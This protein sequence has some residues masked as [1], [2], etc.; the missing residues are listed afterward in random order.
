MSGIIQAKPVSV[1]SAATTKPAPKSLTWKEFQRRYRNREDGNKYEWVRGKVEKTPRSMNQRQLFVLRN[2]NQFLRKLQNTNPELGELS[3]ETDTFFQEFLHRKP[4]IAYFTAAQ[5]A[6]AADG[7]NQIPGFVIEV[8]SP[9]DNIN[10]VTRKVREYFDAG[11]Q[12]VW[13]IFPELQEVHIYENA[14]SVRI[15][16]GEDLC[17]AEAAV[18]GFVLMAEEVF[19]RGQAPVPER[20]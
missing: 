2:L 5:I 9:T 14:K 1:P 12:V 10:R 13:H 4:D 6:A 11:V 3:V 20:F 15:A 8:I 18:P 16:R 17:S 7:E 19:K